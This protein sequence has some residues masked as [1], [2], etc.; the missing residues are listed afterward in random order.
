VLL[1]CCTVSL[2]SIDVSS[3]DEA[4]GKLCCLEG[5]SRNLIK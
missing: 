4:K 3:G 1:T 2:V 5:E